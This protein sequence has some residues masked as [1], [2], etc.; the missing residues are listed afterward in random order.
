MFSVWRR[1]LGGIVSDALRCFSIPLLLLLS[2]DI[3]PNPGPTISDKPTVP[4][5]IEWLELLIAWQEFGHFLPEMPP[6]VIQKIETEKATITE[7]KTALYRKWLAVYPRAT[8]KDVI[9]TLEKIGENAMAENIKSQLKG[10]ATA[11]SKSGIRSTR[12][13]T[14]SK[15]EVAF[16]TQK[17]E[18]R[19]KNELENLEKK[20]SSLFIKVQSQLDEAAKNQD[21][22]RNIIRWMG[23]RTGKTKELSDVRTLDAAFL[24]I[25]PYYDFI[26]CGL[27]VD[28]SEEFLGPDNEI[29]VKFKE[30]KKGADNLRSSTEVRLLTKI[31]IIEKNISRSHT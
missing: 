17:E 12:P 29:V 28:L 13:R 26:D 19:V 1:L 5:L 21:T 14:T 18:I 3:E 7:R 4:Q 16:S 23:S 24:I 2:G 22:F 25:E 15:E 20:F 10:G 30:H 27:I 6:H 11:S 31:L 8:W 9:N